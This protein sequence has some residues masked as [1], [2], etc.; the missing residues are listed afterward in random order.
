[1]NRSTSTDDMSDADLQQALEALISSHKT[2]LLG[3]RNAKGDAEL[4]YAPYLR[5]EQ[6]FYIFISDLAKHTQ[7]LRAHPQASV[8]F[9]APEDGAGNLFA[10]PRLTLH[11][12]AVEI[13]PSDRRHGQCLQALQEKFGNIVTLLRSLPDFHLVQLIPEHG[14]YVA[15]FGKALVV[16]AALR[17]QATAPSDT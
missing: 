9:I 3:T 10:R 2:L 16:D 4:S 8:M 11:C 15:G 1:M 5:D 12:S 13:P 17:L 7:N 6:G 14:S